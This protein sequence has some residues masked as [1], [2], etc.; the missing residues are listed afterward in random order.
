MALP[1]D[2]ERILIVKPEVMVYKIGPRPNNRGYR[3][4]DWNLLKPDWTGRLRIVS[5]SEKCLVRLEDRFSGDLFGECPVDEWP[6]PAVESVLDSSRYFVLRLC[7]PTGRHAFV[8]IGFTDRGD[9]FD[10]NVAISDHFKWVKQSK[11]IEKDE[12]A[13]D[14]KP[15]MDLS[16]KSGETIK[17]NIASKNGSDIKGTERKPRTTSSIAFTGILPPPP[18]AKPNNN[19]KDIVPPGPLYRAA[20]TP[21]PQNVP[22]PSPPNMKPATGNLLDDDWG[23]FSSSAT[24]NSLEDNN[25]S[26]WVNFS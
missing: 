21:M 19:K 6:S 15:P 9:S 3:A 1:D 10:F 4:T 2:Y 12:V 5:K 26:D 8:G 22:A 11:Q 7:D 14:A 24:K 18:G 13:H 20:G 16:F 17:I 25:S 23:D